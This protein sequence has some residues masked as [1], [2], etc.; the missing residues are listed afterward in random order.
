MQVVNYFVI[1]RRTI[2]TVSL[3]TRGCCHYV[4][5]M[6]HVFEAMGV[7]LTGGLCY[8]ENDVGRMLLNFDYI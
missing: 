4:L 3:L 7:Y 2:Y 1:I 6:N 8:F 5:S